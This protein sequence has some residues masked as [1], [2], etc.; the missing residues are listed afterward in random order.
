MPNM[1][2]HVELRS[3][4]GGNRE[5]LPEAG[6]QWRQTKI[7][8]IRT[9]RIESVKDGD[10]NWLAS[11]MTSNVV[12]VHKDGQCACGTEGVKAD[13]QHAFGLYDVERRILSSE[14]TIRD[15]WAIEIDEMDSTMT[16]V[17]AGTGIQAHLKTVIVY[18]RQ[19]DGSWK[20]ARLLELD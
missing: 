7:A 13:L 4:P 16:L 9:A 5:Q 20:I 12:A 17:D 15:H 6:H 1:G 8:T 11:L 3:R 19:E 18:A 10:V 2:T 14:L